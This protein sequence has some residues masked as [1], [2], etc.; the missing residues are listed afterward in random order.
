MAGRP[1]HLADAGLVNAFTAEGIA[2][3]LE[4]GELAARTAARVLP[5]RRVPTIDYGRALVAA[6]PRHWATRASSRHFRWLMAL[7]PRLFETASVLDYLDHNIRLVYQLVCDGNAE[8]LVQ[9]FRIPATKRRGE[10]GAVE[11]LA[12]SP[13]Q[14]EASR[15]NQ[16]KLRERGKVAE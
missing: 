4:S 1:R 2:Y 12:V 5:R 11:R 3:A 6:H 8:E 7:A 14:P 16:L 13:V 15:R 9:D 10:V